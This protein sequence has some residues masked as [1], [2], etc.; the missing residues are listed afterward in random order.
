MLVL[1]NSLISSS[2]RNRALVSETFSGD[3]ANWTAVNTN[4]G[5]IKIYETDTIDGKQTQHKINN[6]DNIARKM[7]KNSYEDLMNEDT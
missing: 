6:R 4:I 1:G 2:Y 3:I 7:L 5:E